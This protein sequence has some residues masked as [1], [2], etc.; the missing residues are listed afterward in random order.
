MR[1]RRA[2]PASAGSLPLACS[3]A[4]FCD[5]PIEASVIGRRLAS[6]AAADNFDRK[7]RHGQNIVTG[8]IGRKRRRLQRIENR[9]RTLPAHINARGSFAPSSAPPSAVGSAGGVLG[10]LDGRRSLHWLETW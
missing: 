4:P 1:V 5:L 7:I 8:Q 9:L 3:V 2:I 10:V 6:R